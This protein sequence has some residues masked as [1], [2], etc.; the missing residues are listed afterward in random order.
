MKVAGKFLLALAGLALMQTQMFAEFKPALKGEMVQPNIEVIEIGPNKIHSFYGVSNSHIIETGKELV[1]IDMQFKKSQ[2]QGLKKYIESLN[3]PL[4]KIILSHSHPDHWFGYTN[5][6][7]TPLSTPGVKDDLDK[8]GE[9]FIKILK[10]K[11]KDS[12]PTEV[13]KVDT[14]LK[15]GKAN[16]DGLEVI[17]EEYTEQEAHHSIAIKIPAYG[18]MIGQDLFY[19]DSHLV[20]SNLERNKNWAR[21]LQSFLDNETETYHTFLTG[22]GKNADAGVLQQDIEYLKELD[23]IIRSGVSKE[24]AKQKLIAKFPEKNPK[25]QGFIDITLRNLFAKDHK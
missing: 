20:A 10:D 8:R 22:H 11:L 15:M 2:A 9:E 16:W 1:L 12:V 23:K 14:S 4:A 7:L 21:L 25:T 17:L 24:E 5:F 6:A 3:K 18:I 13:V 19:N